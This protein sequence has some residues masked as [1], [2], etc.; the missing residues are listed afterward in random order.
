M[1]ALNK[2]KIFLLF[3]ILIIVLVV[4]TLFFNFLFNSKKINFL[5]DKNYCT[6]E[7][8]NAD[9]CADFYE[10]VWGYFLENCDSL[11]C[12]KT[13]FNSCFACMDENVLFSF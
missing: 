2:K 8:K 11:D 6:F 1:K 12:K 3:G 4:F 10:P 5:E 9:V 7:Q 13:F